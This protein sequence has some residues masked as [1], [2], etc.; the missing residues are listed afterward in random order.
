MALIGSTL[1]FAMNASAQDSDDDYD[2][3]DKGRPKIVTGY[4]MAAMVGGGVTGF[5]DGDLN[6]SVD[7]GGAWTARL[8]FGTR[9]LIGAEAAYVGS[10]QDMNVLGLDSNAMLMS[11]GIEGLARVNLMAESPIQPYLFFGIGWKRYSLINEAFNTS[12]VLDRDDVAEIPLGGGV[13]FRWEGFVADARVGYAAAIDSDLIPTGDPEEDGL[14][15][16]NWSG[17]VRVGFEF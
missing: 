5:T 14:D 4:G 9:S 7:T 13:A 10:A 11:N 2:S 15:L 12:S 1:A 3:P 16:N 8:I 17:N 6:D